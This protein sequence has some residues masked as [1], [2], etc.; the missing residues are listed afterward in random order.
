MRALERRHLLT[1]GAVIAS[2]SV[3]TV[4]S[5]QALQPPAGSEPEPIYAAIERHRAAYAA[6]VDALRKHR[7]LDDLDAAEALALDA[8][9]DTV[10]ST[11]P[12]PAAEPALA[13]GF[14]T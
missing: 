13:K 8:L 11:V 10:P 2:A 12:Q 14:R 6:L 4:S 5:L 9:V 7:D 3:L 1:Y